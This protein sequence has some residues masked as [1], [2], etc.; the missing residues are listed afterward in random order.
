VIVRFSGEIGIKGEWTRRSYERLLLKNIEKTL[1]YNKV[2]YEQI[3]QKRGRIYIDTHKAKE[4]ASTLTRVFGISSVSP[5]VRTKSDMNAITLK[6]VE[7]AS[8]AIG[9]GDSFAVRCRRVGKHS[10][11]SLDIC[12]EVG[13]QILTDLRKRKIRVDLTNPRHTISIEVRDEEA[14]IFAETLQGAGGFPISSQAKAVCLLSGGIDSPVACWM[15]MKRG[16]TIIPVYLDNAPLTDQSTE[17]K[18][19]KTAEKLFE[20]SIGFPRRMYIVP[21][22]RNLQIFIE[23]APRK[24][25]C[26]LCK[27][28]MYRIAE[29][30]ADIEKAEGIVTGEAIGE[31]ASQTMQ[32]LRVLDEAALRYPVHR[33]LLGFDKTE[34]EQLARKIGTL[35][36]STAEAKSCSAAPSQPATRAKLEAVQRAEQE[37][38]LDQMISESLRTA[39]TVTV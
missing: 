38:D 20:W 9:R 14:Y 33:P 13:S 24:L 34:T 8:A 29:R 10:Y 17:S 3:V 12:R 21:N 22:G 39:K 26:L 2:A 27:R 25:T 11:S 31:Q 15:V 6:A 35:E 5:A 23:K 18:A 4:T 32:N 16:C 28:I 37:L 36:I 1:A 30:I 19:L 7:A